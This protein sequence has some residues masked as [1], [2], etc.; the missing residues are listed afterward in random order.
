M[1]IGIVLFLHWKGLPSL[2]YDNLKLR[3]GINTYQLLLQFL[4]NES[5][6]FGISLKMISN[7]TSSNFLD[8][9]VMILFY[10]Y[11]I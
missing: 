9:C 5:E 6:N 4:Q 10:I 8:D 3:L 2:S 11:K 7:Q 1:F